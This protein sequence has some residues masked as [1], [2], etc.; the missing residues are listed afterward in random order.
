MS[1]LGRAIRY[2]NHYRRIAVAAYAA[3]FISVAAQ[4]AVPQLMQQIRDAITNR[5]TVASLRKQIGVVLQ[6]AFLFIDAV[7]NNI[8][9]G[10]PDAADEE[11][12]AAASLGPC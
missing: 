12:K 10:R 9:F 4:L 3:L 11:V 5:V 8:R 2:L 7:M 6:D 1:E